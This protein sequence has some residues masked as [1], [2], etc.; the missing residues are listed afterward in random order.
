MQVGHID[1]NITDS[2]GVNNIQFK[3]TN[4]EILMGHGP[5][6]GTWG[7]WSAECSTGICGLETRIEDDGGIWKD[8]SGLN[9]VRFICC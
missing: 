7:D 9:D 4:G 3:C 6:E 2:T 5:N 1:T 8:D